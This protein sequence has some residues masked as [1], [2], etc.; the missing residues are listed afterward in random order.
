MN[1]LA[2][3]LEGGGSGKE[4]KAKLRQGMGEFLCELRDLARD[5]CVTW[6]IVACG[7]R[8]QAFDRFQNTA[9]EADGS[10]S[11]LLVDA[12]G[13]VCATARQHL[14]QR[15]GW[16][17]DFTSECK[18]HLMVQAMET[19]IIADP[20][21]LADYYGNNF[22][23]TAL[24]GPGESLEALDRA[25]VERLLQHS[26]RRTT[27]GEYRKIRDGSALLERIDP[28][29]VQG[30][31]PSCRRLFDTLSDLISRMNPKLGNPAHRNR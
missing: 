4:S 11:V 3:Y 29:A 21:A 17:L 2:I 31:C 6:K 18:V 25:K 30:R 16:N 5:R 15:D 19:W 9:G 28:G 8:D 1:G 10:A 7:G 12:E 22:A 23:R 24:P 20:D 14:R 26:T 13:P 27:K